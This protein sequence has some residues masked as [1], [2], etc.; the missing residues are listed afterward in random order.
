VSGNTNP[1]E[2]F[3][4]LAYDQIL[5]RAPTGAELSECEQFLLS[6]AEI[7]RDPSKLTAI[8]GGAKAAVPPSADPAQRAR[9]NLVL[10]LYNH[11]DFIMI[12]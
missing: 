5:G 11:N 2:T 6:Q 10:V 4:R 12:R 8:A 9:E 7:L 1:P 3:V